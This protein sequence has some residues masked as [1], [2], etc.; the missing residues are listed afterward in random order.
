MLKTGK[1]DRA[2][3]GGSAEHRLARLLDS[4]VLAR[5]VPHLPPQT[6][7]QII[8]W[9]GLDAST[10]LVTSA[11]PAQ[12]KTIFDLDLW[13]PAKPGDDGEFNADRFGEWLDAL[14]ETGE[15]IAARTVA[16]LDPHVVINGLSR[17]VRVLDPGIF[18]PIA[19][20]DDERIERHEALREGDYTSADDPG[21]D[22][23][24][25]EL[26]GYILRARRT[27]A[28]DAIVTLLTALDAEHNDFFHAVMAGCRRLSNSNP[29]IDGLDDLLQER[30]QHFQEGSD[31]REARLSEQ[32][33]A[34]PADARAFLQ[35]ARRSAER[36]PGTNPIVAAYFRAVDDVEPADVP[37]GADNNAPQPRQRLESGDPAATVS[38][39][40]SVDAAESVATVIEL[41]TEAGLMPDRP[42]ALLASAETEDPAAAKLPHL[43]RLMDAASTD[44]T[45]FFERSRE[46]A[47]VTNVLLAG[48]SIQA[49]PFTPQE[50][51]DAAASICNLG[52]EVSESLEGDQILITAFEAGWSVLHTDVSMI[53]AR[54]LT[55]LVTG[56]RSADMDFQRGLVILRRQLA[57]HTDAGTPWLARGAAD[58]LA[59]L[60]M[61][62]STALRGL[63]SECPVIP[64]AMTALLERSTKTVSQ[65]KF[66]FISTTDQIGDVRAFLKKLPDVLLN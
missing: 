32:G 15:S 13:R 3:E 34:T 26:S 58:V 4:Q 28:W 24:E 22:G 27:D 21:G 2:P 52:L 1:N 65:T 39:D 5:V 48:C 64:D 62:A 19:Q 56:M 11:T 10:E 47:F 53:V 29:E 45:A 54:E 7:H 16:N 36:V 59:M 20:S 49:R 40:I 12:L 35:M 57:T 31:A 66:T 44:E 38:A 9:R 61:T 23:L 18:E 6:L 50:A 30:E 51:S 37:A 8:R 63:M 41:L 55:A 43:R 25:C 42:R 33:Y 14:A 17:F 60:D 46:L